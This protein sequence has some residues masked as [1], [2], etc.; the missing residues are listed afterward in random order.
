M[1]RFEPTMELRFVKRDERRILQ[2]KWE[3]VSGREEWRDVPLVA[4][5]GLE[6]LEGEI[7]DQPGVRQ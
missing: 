2:Q 4:G 3:A 1:D 7:E 5:S 6:I